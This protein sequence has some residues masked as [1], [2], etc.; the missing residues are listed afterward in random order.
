M[1]EVTDIVKPYFPKNWDVY[2]WTDYTTVEGNVYK[3]TLLHIF[4]KKCTARL[5]MFIDAYPDNPK[6]ESLLKHVVQ[7]AKKKLKQWKKEHLQS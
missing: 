6:F 3:G 7:L 4:F 1:K 2:A 5:D